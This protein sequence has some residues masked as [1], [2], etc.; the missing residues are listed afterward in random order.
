MGRLLHSMQ[1][2]AGLSLF[3]AY[4]NWL[5]IGCHSQACFFCLRRQISGWSVKPGT[6]LKKLDPEPLNVKGCDVLL[7]SVASCSRVCLVCVS[8]AALVWLWEGTETCCDLIAGLLTPFHWRLCLFSRHPKLFPPVVLS[9]IAC[10]LLYTHRI[11][12]SGGEDS[13][14]DCVKLCDKFSFAPV[15]MWRTGFVTVSKIPLVHSCTGS[16]NSFPVIQDTRSHYSGHHAFGISV[17]ET[18]RR[19]SA[20]RFRA[21]TWACGTRHKYWS[22]S[23]CSMD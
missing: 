17:W 10:C 8:T 20:Q 18:L 5:L 23:K 15:W 16:R 21:V 2:L 6:W 14:F 11:W 4:L 22:W 19:G 12:V 7:A 1:W 3:I 13:C 9:H